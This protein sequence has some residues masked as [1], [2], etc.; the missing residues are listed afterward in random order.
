MLMKKENLL[1]L[2]SILYPTS[3]NADMVVCPLRHADKDNILGIVDQQDNLVKQIL[4]T[5]PGSFMTRLL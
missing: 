2:V 4:Y 3:W 1:S 5:N